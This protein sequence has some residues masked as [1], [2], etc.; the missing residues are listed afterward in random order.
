MVDLP[1]PAASVPSQ[2][3]W[4]EKRRDEERLGGT[5]GGYEGG[6][7]L[8]WD[9]YDSLEKALNIKQPLLRFVLVGSYHLEGSNCRRQTK[10]TTLLS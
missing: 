3:W 9:R 1:Q 7:Q 8:P 2:L 5:R 6:K 4:V 10:H